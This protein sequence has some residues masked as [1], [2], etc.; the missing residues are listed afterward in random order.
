[1]GRQPEIFLFLSV[2]SRGM[3]GTRNTPL[4]FIDLNPIEGRICLKG[5]EMESLVKILL[6]VMSGMFPNFEK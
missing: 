2:Q 5:L 3:D 4:E 6:P 1:M